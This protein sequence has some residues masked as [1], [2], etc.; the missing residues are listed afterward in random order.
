[1]SKPRYGWWGYVKNMIRRYPALK[2]EYEELHNSSVVASYG[3]CG[4][5]GGVSRA[6][7][8]IAI[9][10]LPS[11]AQR[12]YES[13]RRAIKLTERYKNGRDRL[14]VVRMVLWK[15]CTLQDA[16]LQIPCSI[17]TAKRY[18]GDFIKQVAYNFGLFD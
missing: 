15:K 16:A 18:H 10:E 12:E 6:T 7:E 3:A 13:V 9:R 5:S 11:N 14:T 4:H 8:G 17:A 1:M 2:A